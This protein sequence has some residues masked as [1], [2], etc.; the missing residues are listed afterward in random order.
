M[1][2]E[3]GFIR[4]RVA[5]SNLCPSPKVHARRTQPPSEM[6]RFLSCGREVERLLPFACAAIGPGN[7][8]DDGIGSINSDEAMEIDRN[9]ASP[10]PII[11]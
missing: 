2:L 9:R 11:R 8:I 3:P 4:A 6:N 10:M 1:D 5:A 7:A